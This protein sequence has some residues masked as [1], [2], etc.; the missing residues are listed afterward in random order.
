[1]KIL[2]L[3]F[4][5]SLIIPINAYSYTLTEDDKSQILSGNILIKEAKNKEDVPGLIAAFS[6][7]SDL[8]DIWNVFVDY[9]NFTKVFSD[10][11]NLKVLEQNENGAVVEFWVDAVLSDLNYVL[12]RK[13]DIPYRKLTWVKRSGDLK[14][15]EGS[16]EVFDL[17]FENKKMVVYSSFVEV[18]FLIPTKLVRWGAMRKAEEMCIRI[19]NWVESP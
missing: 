14:L 18:G 11:K 19:R 7:N 5:A 15:I 4:I 13:Y 9:E 10:V 16:W 6:V 2:I 3:Y 1:M 17:P 8:K 12:Y